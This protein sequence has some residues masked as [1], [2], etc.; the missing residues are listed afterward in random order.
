MTLRAARRS[1]A[2]AAALLSAGAAVR[3]Q[4]V[5]TVSSWLSPTHILSETQKEWCGQLEQRSAGKV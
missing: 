4:T 2:V 5:L 3:A 1:I